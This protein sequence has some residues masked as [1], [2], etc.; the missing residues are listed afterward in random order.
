MLR[1]CK[2]NFVHCAGR[3]D[4]QL[5]W[6]FAAY[7]A[8]L[9]CEIVMVRGSELTLGQWVMGPY[10]TL[11]YFTFGVGRS[12]ALRPHLFGPMR[13]PDITEGHGPTPWRPQGISWWPQHWKR[14]KLTAYFYEIAKF[15]AN[16]Q[17]YRLQK[18]RLWP[19]FS[20]FVAVILCGRHWRTPRRPQSPFKLL[21]VLRT[22]WGPVILH[23]SS[24]FG[25]G[26]NQGSKIPDI[27]GQYL[28]PFFLRS[29]WWSYYYSSLQ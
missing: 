24:S 26:S 19:S 1:S 20:L 16:S 8:V 2:S 5:R 6:S 17:S 7:G 15:T 27:I 25:H 11:P 13:N 10:L 18:T 9:C 12:P 28:R 29:S 23:S 14:E 3:S 21:A 22:V 4:L